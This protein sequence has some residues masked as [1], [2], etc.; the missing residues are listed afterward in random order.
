MNKATK[1]IILV[2]MTYLYQI[3]MNRF[4]L[5]SLFLLLNLFSFAQPGKDGALTVSAANTVVNCYTAVTANVTA[6]STTVTT[7]GTCAFTCGDLVMI[8]QAQGATIN[9]TNTA[10]YGTV[11]A[12]NNSGLY[13]FNYVTQA[14]GAVL[15]VQNPWVNNYTATGR[16]QIVKV[17]QYTNLTVNVGGSI[18]PLA[19]N[20]VGANRTGGVVAIHATG[21]ITVNGTIHANGFGFRPG[22]LE[23]T[24]SPA[25]GGL[26]SMYVTTNGAES[27]AK[28]ES[29]AGFFDVYDVSGGRFGRGAPA[30]GGGGGNGHNCGGGAGS[31]GNN[32]N[33]YNGQGVMCT[34]CVGPAAWNLDPFVIA[35]GGVLS[36]SSGGGRG[37]YSFGSSNQNALVL[38]PSAAAWAG[39]FRDPFG[40]EGGRPLNITAASRI[41]FGGGGGA[42]DRNNTAN[43]VGGTGGG[44]VY[45]IGNSITGAGQINSNG[46]D[47][48]NQIALGTG[49]ANDAPSGAGGGGTVIIRS[50]ALAG[51]SLNARGGKGGDQAFL[52]TES[53]GP[54]G[55]GGGGYIAFSAGA[56]VTNITGGVNGITLSGSLTEFT[57][58]GATIGAAGQTAAVAPFALTYAIIPPIVTNATTPV[59]VGNPINFTTTGLAGFS[60]AWS[61]PPAFTSALQNPT[62]GSAALTNTG[63]FQVIYTSP[64]GCKDTNYVPVVVN[65]N[66]IITPSVTNPLCNGACTGTINAVPSAGTPAYSFLW[67]TGATTQII[68]SLCVGAYTVTVTDANGCI[69]TSLT[70]IT[71]PTAIAGTTTNVN[72]LCNG[73]ATGSITVNAAGGTGALQYSLNGGP[74][75]ASNLFS[76]LT[77]GAYTITVQDANG[78]TITIPTNL[79]NP[80]LLTANLVSTTPATCGVSNGA[81]TVT[82]AGG[83]GALSYD[84]N[85]GPVN[86][87]G[88]FTGLAAGAYSVIVTDA[89]GCTAT[90]AAITVASSAGPTASILASTNVTCFGGVNGSVLI[91]ATGGTA[92]ITYTIDL[93][94]PTAPVGP[95]ASNSFINLVAGT[96]TVT[97]TDANGCTGTTTFIITSPPQLTYT[98][99]FTNVTC[100]AACNGTIT[101]TPAGGTPGYTFSS[102][103]GLTFSAANPMTGLCA[104]NTFV[105]VQDANGCLANSLIVITQPAAMNATFALTNPVCPGACDGQIVVSTTTGGTGPY[106]YSANGGPFQVSTTLTGLCA[107]ANTI[108]AQDANGCQFTSVQVLI[109]P[110]GFTINVIDTTESNCGFNNG[111]FIVDATGGLAPYDYYNITTGAGPQPTG[112]FPNLVAG[113]YDVQVI[114]A[115]GCVEQLFVGVN[116]VEM[117]GFLDAITNATCYGSCDGTVQTHAINGAPPIQYELDLNGVFQITGDFTGL[118]E[119]SHI[120]TMVDNGFCI[121]TVPFIIT[122]PDSILF[123]STVTNIPCSGGSTGTINITGVTGGNGVYQFSIDGG[124]TYQASPLFTGLAVG[125]YPL[126]VMDANGCLG[127]G[128]AI[129]TEAPPLSYLTNITDL[130][131]FG[132]STGFLQLVAS[133]GTPAYTYSI[134]GG[135][136]F[137]AG[138]TFFGLAAGNY[139]VVIQDAAG[140]QITGI[141]T[142]N[143]P[144]PVVAGYILTPTTCNGDCDGVI[145]I[146]AGG[147]TPSYLYSSDGGVTYGLS[148]SLTGLCA[149]TYSVFTKDANNCLVGSSVTIVE[150][151]V[152][153]FTPVT[154]PET[155]AATNGTITINAAAGG[156]PGYTYSINGA[157]GPFVV[158]NNFTGLNSGIYNLMVED[159]NGCQFPGTATIL[160][161]LSP[162]INSNFVTNVSCNAACDGSLIATATGGTGA[163][164]FDIGGVPQATGNFPGLCAGAYTLTVTD[165]NGCTDVFAFNITEPAVLSFTSTPVNLIC[166]NDLSGQITFNPA[167]GTT[168]YMYSFDNGIT[169]SGL[170]NQTNLSAGN[171]NLILQDAN[172]CTVTGLETLT[173]PT[174]VVITAQTANDPLCFASCD[175]DVSV[176]VTGGTVAGLYNYTWSG[177]IAGPASSTAT[178][179]CSGTYTVDVA[180]NNGCTVSTT[181]T[182]VDPAPFLITAVNPTDVLCTGDCNG[183]LNIN[184]PTGVQFSIDGGATTQAASNFTGLC[185]GTYFI[186]V[187]NAN[188]CVATSIG[189]IN[190]PLPLQV[191]CTPDSIYCSGAGL[192]LFAFAFGGVGPYNYSWDNGINTQSQTVNPVGIVTFTVFATDA[193]GCVSPTASTTYS[194]LPGYTA[195]I[196]ATDTITC[197]GEPITITVSMASGNPA[198]EYNWNNGETDSTITV[199]NNGPFSYT[200]IV[201]DQCFDYDTLTVNIDNYAPPAV[202]FTVDDTSGCTPLTVT[203]TNTTPP[204]MVGASCIWT[205][206]DG[207]VIPGCGTITPTFTTPGCYGID[208]LVTS[209]EGCTNTLSQT[210]VFCVHPNP[211]AEFTWTPNKPTYF[212]GEVQFY[213]Q[214]LLADSYSWDFAGLG[215]SS[216]QNPQYNF[217]AIDT[218]IFTIC[219]AVATNQGCV[220]TTCKDLRVYE[221]FAVYVPNVFTPDGDG[222]NDIFYA[223]VGGVEPTEFEFMIFNRWG[224]LIYMGTDFKKGW[225]GTHNQQ[226]CKEDVYVW[227]I[228]LKDYQ[229][230]K[231]DFVGHVTLLR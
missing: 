106:T 58:N 211:V 35:S 155:C 107:G 10:A 176:T 170:D 213:D 86:A 60:Y 85:P 189:I 8:Y 188:G 183:I 230:V 178:G 174:Q 22:P 75:Q 71:Q 206:S 138:F 57:P 177:G 32:G 208:L 31:N 53:E 164:T 83:T 9:T 55:G 202:S 154:T 61:G 214:S 224:E 94:G 169:F 134:N 156:T 197:L 16:V 119:G 210:N 123:S 104:G 118:C 80:P 110:P 117:D 223:V 112:D 92:P 26:M 231:Y 24:T 19:W 15:T 194:P 209:P 73:G 114:D 23:N 72:P 128:T 102:N 84:L 95:Q 48:L 180:D 216:L 33:A 141:E 229:E 151:T 67:T 139:N 34:A 68:N 173:E 218:G 70:N 205:F 201:N 77:A 136:S 87:T 192:P 28:G 219:L 226:K 56:P 133:G 51:V 185:V 111:G 7:T 96:Y 78:C 101:V 12:Y 40:G 49:G 163:L 46:T 225:D 149:G 20:D 43:Q 171:Y 97:I 82:A 187:T 158:T 38:A 120:V 103:N 130:T 59:C 100:N 193:N 90:V 79:T 200:V 37:G 125:T 168:P 18:V 132:N 182:L 76:G 50:T 222:T 89:N 2:H 147:G 152:V 215:V 166:F 30:N 186:E 81:I 153:T 99:T 159:A 44:I 221:D 93:A 203:L 124:I 98:T 135:A 191:I 126:S 21:T 42:G 142:I 162:V 161:E 181:F 54:G 140:C 11:T 14:V 146:T 5:L 69:A 207:T 39:D 62:I 145:D 63:T 41:F 167:G 172:G 212:H 17:P 91:G 220:D 29:I 6:G 121:F 66:P 52:A 113:G 45:L 25:G 199:I 131:C 27:A 227:K 217:T 143:E 228:R 204:A 122:E 116:D 4:T 195:S 137:V 47:A 1:R 184:A 64:G 150:P 129:I 13:E 74:L 198:Y 127:S 105:V 108:I 36:T 144:T 3:P 115:N 65:P 160:D 148:S 165:A 196:A 157:T 179:L 190:E 109:D 88:V 175:G